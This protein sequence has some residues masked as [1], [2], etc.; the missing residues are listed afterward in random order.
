[1]TTKV[2][3]FV[4][5]LD[6]IGIQELSATGAPSATTFLA[7]NNTW[8]VVDT[9]SD[10]E[11]QDLVGGMV[12]GASSVQNG[13]TVAYD[14]P[15][16]K[17]TFDVNDPVITLTGEVTGSATMTNLGNVSIAAVVTDHTIG[18]VSGLQAALDLK[19]PLANPALTGVP[20]STTAA[21]NTNNTQI[22]TTAFVQ[23]EI[24][25]LIGGAPGVLDTLNELAAAINDDA[26][27][28][29]SVTALLGGKVDTTSAQALSSAV[30]AM[31]LS[32]TTL[33]LT[34]GDGTTD[35]VTVA[36][37][38]TTYTAGGG[39]DLAGGAFSVEPDLRDGITHVGVSIS[40]YIHFNGNEIDFYTGGA[41][42]MRLENDGDLH[43][44]GDVIAFSTTI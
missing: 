15:N 34:R 22:A 20:T 13:I 43:C 10:E 37:S 2:S 30:D 24:T 6:A 44:N 16:G 11:V 31:T 36:A 28:A 35:T 40:S 29:A 9:Q 1:M 23:T 12:T 14:D 27:Y 5:A 26:S 18:G 39:I 8:A 21:A 41:I 19:A 42:R 33:T 38:D 4:V 7:G 32:G 25:D 17:L 3:N